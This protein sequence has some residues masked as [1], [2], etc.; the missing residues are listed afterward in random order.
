MFTAVI[1]PPLNGYSQRG[2]TSLRKHYIT[3]PLLL[4]CLRLL[5]Y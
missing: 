3:R 2:K 4:T 1:F 5:G